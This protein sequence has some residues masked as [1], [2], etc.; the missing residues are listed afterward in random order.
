MTIVAPPDK[1]TGQ[2]RIFGLGSAIKMTAS[3]TNGKA[4]LLNGRDTRNSV[5]RKP[6]SDDVQDRFFFP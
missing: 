6:F 2:P 4:I 5:W 3:R 1:E